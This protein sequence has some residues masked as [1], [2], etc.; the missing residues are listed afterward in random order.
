MGEEKTNNNNN[1]KQSTPVEPANPSP[2]PGTPLTK[3]DSMEP[4]QPA[5]P[6]QE[7][8]THLRESKRGV[9]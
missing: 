5:Q 8:G 3:G 2:T 6:S 7:P 9:E 1:P 4:V